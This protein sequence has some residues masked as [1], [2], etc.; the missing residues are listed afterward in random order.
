MNWL[1][2]EK[3]KRGDASLSIVE[4]TPINIFVE[5]KEDD[6][7]RGPVLSEKRGVVAT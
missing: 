6:S 5:G 4:Q 2:S 1:F 7:E 3:L